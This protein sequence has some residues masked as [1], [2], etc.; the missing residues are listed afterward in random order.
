MFQF[1]GLI[2]AMGVSILLTI[3]FSFLLG[4]INLLNVE[5][6][7]I[8]TFLIT[9]ISIGILAPM[10]NRDTPYFAVF[11][12]SLSLTVINFL[13]SMVV[14]HIPVFTAPLE[15]NSSITTSI[16]TSLV[17]AYLLITILKRMGRWDY[18]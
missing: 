14:L 8:V 3:F 11:L 9:Y 10:W 2:R 6:T 15:V 5:W 4:L 18:D 1:T 16:V 17:T 7:I 13:F 12:G